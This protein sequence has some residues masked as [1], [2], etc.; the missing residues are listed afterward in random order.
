MCDLWFCAKEELK[1][2]LLSGLG[3]D[4]ILDVIY[5]GNSLFLAG[6]Q[7]RRNSSISIFNSVIVGYPTGIL[8]DASKGTPTDDNIA[9]NTLLI[10][11]TVLAGCSTPVSYAPST[12]TPTGWTSDDA[13]NWF[14]TTGHANSIL[15]NTSDAMLT[16][17]YD[18]GNPDFTPKAGSPLLG[19][20]SFSDSKVSDAFF[21]P[22]TFIGASGDSGD[23]A[24]WW[25]GWSIL[26]LNL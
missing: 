9:A 12:T 8:I 13:T 18:Y 25:K 22:V 15:T 19:G 17:P 11:N 20:A 23:D 16:A 14:L 1:W 26:G 7:I 5:V 2:S 24:N 21:T 6:A 3:N 4:V 10:Q